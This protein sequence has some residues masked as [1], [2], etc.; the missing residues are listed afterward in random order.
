MCFSDI[1]SDVFIRR[2]ED[3]P[4]TNGSFT[5]LLPVNSIVTITSFLERGL[6]GTHPTPPD[7]VP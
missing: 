4:V 1:I 3:I 6:H 2:Q 7:P 5:I